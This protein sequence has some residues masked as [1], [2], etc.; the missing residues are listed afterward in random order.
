MLAR[1]IV[2]DHDGYITEQEYLASGVKEETAS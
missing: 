2:D 1:K